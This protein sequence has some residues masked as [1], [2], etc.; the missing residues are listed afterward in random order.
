MSFW[1]GSSSRLAI[2]DVSSAI[3]QKDDSESQRRLLLTN[4]DKQQQ[5][6]LRILYLVTS[7]AEYNNGRRFTKRGDDRVVN[8][9]MPVLTEGVESMLSFGYQV[10]VYLICHWTMTAERRK[11]IRDKL[12]LSVGLEVWDDATPLGYKLERNQ[13]HTDFVTRGLA[14]QHRYVIK[15]KFADYDFFVAFEDDMLVKGEHVKQ[16]LDV[17]DEISRL[18]T[19]A[20]NETKIQGDLEWMRNAFHAPLS[21][22]QLSRMIPGFIRVEVL[23]TED[24]NGTQLELDP[25]P[26]DLEFDGKNRTVDPRP[27]CL[28]SNKTVNV[29][30]PPEPTSSK[31]FIW[32]TGIKGLS[33]REVPS[34]GWVTLLGGSYVHGRKHVIGDYW[35]G[36]DGAFGSQKRPDPADPRFLNN[37]G[38]WMATRQQIWEWHTE[39]C[40][41]GF[42]PPFNSPHFALDG[43]DLRNVRRE[44]GLLLASVPTGTHILL[45]ASGRVLVWRY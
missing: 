45:V 13:N 34:L 10:H 26:V 30:I 40:P 37:Q 36:R 1:Y 24:E 18:R 7:L 4:D 44:C 5:Q 8:Y 25:I 27:C 12:P 6:P 33:V 39:H 19:L 21:K 35:S 14:R 23:R 9:M 15:D 2:R 28:L 11:M 32:E 20:S 31:L 16:Y 38:G 41:G 29:H 22:L 3:Q 43:L 17:T 42:L